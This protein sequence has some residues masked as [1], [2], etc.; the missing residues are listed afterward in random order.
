MSQIVLK[1][2]LFWKYVNQTLA[3]WLLC[4]DGSTTA[5]RNA[6]IAWCKQNNLNTVMLCLNNDRYMSLF[7]PRKY[8]RVWDDARVDITGRY[9]MQLKAAGLIVAIV[10]WDN[11]ADPEGKYAP[12]WTCS[13][14][15]HAQFISLVC[16]ALNPY[17]DL[18]LIGCESGRGTEGIPGRTS[19]WVEAAID[20][21]KKYASGR[22]VGT[23]EQGVG[24][25]DNKPYM[26]RRVPNNADFH[27]YETSNHPANGNDVPVSDMVQEVTFLVSRA[28]GVPIIVGEH[29]TDILGAHSMAQAR[30]MA[31]IDGVYGVDGPM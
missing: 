15:L 2:A 19:G 16:P 17:V 31:G 22:L 24:W 7:K 11:P 28:H 12:A 23:H 13:D 4:G 8:M 30:A 3:S 25:K 1:I 10:F 5:M 14:D 20:V 6:Y 27:I 18:Y 26:I 21:T 9:I 29:N